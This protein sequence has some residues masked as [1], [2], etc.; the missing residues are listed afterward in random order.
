MLLRARALPNHMPIELLTKPAKGSTAH[1]TQLQCAHRQ[2]VSTEAVLHLGAC[3]H[4]GEVALRINDSLDVLGGAQRLLDR[5][6]RF[7][8]R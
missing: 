4:D 6:A 7:H 1:P 5:R 2:A 3:L 8:D